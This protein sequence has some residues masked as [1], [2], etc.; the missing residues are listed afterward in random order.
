MGVWQ[1]RRGSL[2]RFPLCSQGCTFYLDLPGLESQV[3]QD[4]QTMPSGEQELSD[5]INANGGA[6]TDDLSMASHVVLRHEQQELE[7]PTGDAVEVGIAW[8]YA[9]VAAQELL[10]VEDEVS[11]WHS[12]L[13]TATWVSQHRASTPRATSFRASRHIGRSGAWEC[14][15]WGGW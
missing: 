14:R 2:M 6:V 3:L 15:A 13:E 12:W 9:C 10:P 8:P 5:L 7:G 4:N 1:A 11:S